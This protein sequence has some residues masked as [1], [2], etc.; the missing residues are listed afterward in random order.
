MTPDSEQRSVSVETV[1]SELLGRAGGAWDTAEVADHLDLSP[2]QVRGRACRGR[3]LFLRG[4]TGALY[5]TVW[6]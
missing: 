4:E 1:R 5:Y 2:E 3:L 6:T